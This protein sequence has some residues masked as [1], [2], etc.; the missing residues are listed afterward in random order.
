MMEIGRICMKI[1][2][3][4]ANRTCV[5]VDVFDDNYVLVDGETRRKK[6]NIKHLEP[7]NKVVKLKKDASR[8]DVKKV[9]SDLGL[10]FFEPKS[11]KPAPRVK[12]AKFVKEK[13]EVSK[14]KSKKVESKTKDAP[15]KVESKLDSK[16][17]TGA[18]ATQ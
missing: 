3:R 13:V 14:G 11:K 1:A 2:G 17:S 4:D 16:S 9:F 18:K 7:L 8:A 12:K 15:K 6:V 10:G 5:V